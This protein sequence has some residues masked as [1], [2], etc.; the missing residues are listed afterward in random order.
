[1][2]QPE[3][4]ARWLLY[5]DA[6]KSSVEPTDPLVLA[7]YNAHSGKVPD[8]NYT[9][10]CD[11]AKHVDDKDAIIAFFLSGATRE[12]ISRS[13]N[14][15]EPVLHIFEQLVVDASVF[16]NKL[17]L[18]RYAQQYKRQATKKGAELVELGIVQGPLA[19]VQYFRHGHEEIPVD[20]KMYAREMMQQAFYFGM[21]SRGN[22]IKSNVAKESLRWLAATSSLLKDYDRILGDAHDSDEALLEIEKRKMTFTP[23]ELG[24][25]VED[26]IH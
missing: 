2:R 4:D 11:L 19:L 5:L 22:S 12:E 13:L 6:V 25:N 3:P 23:E 9:Y 17:E 20:P 24:T 10:A 8:N 7:A 14:I 16:R 21:L 1:M 15:P 18:L 26:F